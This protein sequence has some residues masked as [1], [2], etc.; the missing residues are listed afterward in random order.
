MKTIQL[1]ESWLGR[2]QNQFE[3]E[4]MQKLREFLL[5]RKRHQAV[6]YPPGAQ[7]FNAMN[8]TPFEKRT[9]RDSGTGPLPWTGAGAR[10]VFFGAT[11]RQD[12]AF[13]GQ[14]LS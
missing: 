4:Y 14:Y 11:R 9:C 13:I 3:Q 8:S 10:P 5:T 6:I 2:L 1:H 12:S 7:I